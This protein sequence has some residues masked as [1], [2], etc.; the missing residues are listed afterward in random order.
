MSVRGSDWK[1]KPIFHWVTKFDNCVITVLTV[2]SNFRP[3]RRL[4]FSQS[5]TRSF[6]K[7]FEQIIFHLYFYSSNRFFQ[8]KEKTDYT[9][10]SK[11]SNMVVDVTSANCDD[12]FLY[13]A[14]SGHNH[15]V[16]YNYRT[17]DSHIIHHNYL[18]F[19][20]LF[21][22]F[23]IGGE[24]SESQCLWNLLVLHTLFILI[25]CSQTVNI[26]HKTDVFCV[27]SVIY[28]FVVINTL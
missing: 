2:L 10:E 23:T 5:P 28:L 7:L 15:I 22:D 11:F 17:N 19:D 1:L 26:R 16:V 14:D 4:D 27:I 13:I 21:G 12:A 24:Y 8:L 6:L 25:Q 3:R 18:H 9:E 20:P